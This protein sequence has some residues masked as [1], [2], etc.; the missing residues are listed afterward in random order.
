LVDNGIDKSIISQK[1]SLDI[2][3][4][5]LIKL[6]TNL[7]DLIEGGSLVIKEIKKKQSLMCIV[8]DLNRL[9]C[10]VFVIWIK[11]KEI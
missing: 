2:L 7:N 4:S 10:K 3:Y 5:G 9:R 11:S 8:R 6:G 1:I